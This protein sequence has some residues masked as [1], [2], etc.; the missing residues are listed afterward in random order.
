MKYLALL[1]SLVIAAPVASFNPNP[2]YQE[3]H[4]QDGQYYEQEYQE[5]YPQENQYYDQ[6]YEE[7]YPQEY[8]VDDQYYDT[9]DRI[10]SFAASRFVGTKTGGLN[11]DRKS[12]IRRDAALAY[13]NNPARQ[14]SFKARYK[15]AY[16]AGFGFQQAGLNPSIKADRRA[17][18]GLYAGVQ[19]IQG[20]SSRYASETKD[21]ASRNYVNQNRD[22]MRVKGAPRLDAN[23]ADT[24]LQ[25]AD[26]QRRQAFTNRYG[27]MI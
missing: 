7:A 22:A 18:K 5:T 3:A 14:Q 6:E 2:E 15:P 17:H 12:A 20:G 26:Q 21:L 24:Y 19:Q 23:G 16:Q 4:P 13:E 9:P 25:Q 1:V 10:S 27:G 11:T 8:Q